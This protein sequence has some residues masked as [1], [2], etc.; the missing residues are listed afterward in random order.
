[1]D[2]RAQFIRIAMARLNCVYYFRPQRLAVAARMYRR[3]LERKE[4]K[5]G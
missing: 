1:M 4:Q 5:N 2:E 3:Y